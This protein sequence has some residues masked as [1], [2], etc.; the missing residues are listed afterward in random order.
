MADP[1]PYVGPLVPIPSPFPNLPLP[2]PYWINQLKQMLLLS[3]YDPDILYVAMAFDAA[4]EA[5]YTY[6]EP[7]TKQLI[8]EGTGQSW[9]CHART[10]I[11]GATRGTPLAYDGFGQF[12]YG[13]IAGL[14]TIAF[15]QFVGDVAG[16][17]L[18]NWIS[19][20][21]K[22]NRFCNSNLSPFRGQLWR[23]GA[24]YEPGVWGAYGTCINGL[25]QDVGATIRV[26]PGQQYTFNHW[27]S[28]KN[29]DNLPCECMFRHIRRDTGEVIAEGRFNDFTKP[30]TSTI[31]FTQGAHDGF[32]ADYYIDCEVQQGAGFP[33]RIVSA[34]GGCIAR[35]W[36]P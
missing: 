10:T 24:P 22:S 15:W 33:S 13:M 36:F 16:E 17:G 6:I 12:V 28:L 2:K 14:D 35:S 29:L 1:P 3:C 7:S 30:N 8:H 27:G 21:Q 20:I 26:Q 11:G 23:Y 19:Q 4:L 5:V 9:I 34:S 31:L 32:S 25:G 18:L